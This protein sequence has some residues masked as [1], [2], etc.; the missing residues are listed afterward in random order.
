MRIYVDVEHGMYVAVTHL[1]NQILSVDIKSNNRKNSTE[2]ILFEHGMYFR[3]A[4]LKTEI[5]RINQDLSMGCVKSCH[6]ISASIW[7]G[8][9]GEFRNWTKLS[10]IVSRDSCFQVI[11]EADRN[12]TLAK[13]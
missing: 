8:K 7:G 12:Q 3:V 1:K 6:S 11:D 13:M 5:L 9:K 2:N 10:N 4:T